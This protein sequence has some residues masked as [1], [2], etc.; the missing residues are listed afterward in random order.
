MKIR[1]LG[2]RLGASVCEWVAGITT[3]EQ[4]PSF[5]FARY[6]SFFSSKHLYLVVVERIYRHPNPNK[7]SL[8]PG[9]NFITIS[10]VNYLACLFSFGNRRERERGPA[11]QN[12]TKVFVISIVG[13]VVDR[14]RWSLQTNKQILSNC[15]TFREKSKDRDPNPPSFWK[16]PQP[17]ESLPSRHIW[18]CE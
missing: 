10:W 17:K 9:G 2:S 3:S 11:S 13:L 15:L 12:W 8:Y 14:E 6:G 16:K 18:S 5:P 7:R 1:T 4:T